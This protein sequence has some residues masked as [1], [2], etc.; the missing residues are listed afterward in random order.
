M[1]LHNTNAKL[2]LQVGV[3]ITN[4]TAGYVMLARGRVTVKLGTCG[5]LRAFPLVV[6]V[7][8]ELRELTIADVPTQ[9]K[10]IRS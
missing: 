4:L 7:V 2:V 1:H 3:H 10:H 9:H 6:H 5:I 8:V